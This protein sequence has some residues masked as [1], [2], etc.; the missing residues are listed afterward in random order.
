ME[1]HEFSI[2][3][4]VWNTTLDRFNATNKYLQKKHLN[5]QQQLNCMKAWWHSSIPCD[6]NMMFLKKRQKKW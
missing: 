5:Y 6:L 4:I 2:M 3:I 1:K